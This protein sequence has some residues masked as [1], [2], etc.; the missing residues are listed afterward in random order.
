MTTME[1]LVDRRIDR[2]NIAKTN[3]YH[4]ARSCKCKVAYASLEAARR[5][6]LI[7]PMT[8]GKVDGYEEKAYRCNVCWLW[9][10]G[11]TKVQNA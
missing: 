9:H 3:R 11:R 10:V 4:P 1:L 7:Q 2:S 6:A 8:T 5:R